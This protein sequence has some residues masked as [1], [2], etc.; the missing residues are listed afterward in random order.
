[1]WYCPY[2]YYEAVSATFLDP[3]VF[4]IIDSPPL[5]HHLDTYNNI[6]K[7]LPQCRWALRDWGKLP[8]ACT[9]PK[10]EK[11][12]AKGRPIVSFVGAMMRS[13]THGLA[14]IIYLML[15]QACP[16]ALG[17]GDAHHQ[18]FSLRQAFH[19]LST[20]PADEPFDVDVYNQDLSGFFTSIS[21]ERL[22]ASL[23]LMTQWYRGK[24]ATHATVFTATHQEPDPTIRVHR[25]RARFAKSR[26]HTIHLTR[27]PDICSAVLLLNYCLVGNTLLQQIRGAPMGSPASPALCDMVVA[28]S[29]QSWTHTYRNLTYNLKHTT[30]PMFTISGFFATRYVDNRLCL[31]PTCTR[32]NT[33]F[34][35][36]LSPQVYGHPIHLETE[37]GLDFL[38]FTIQPHNYS[39][40]YIPTRHL[41]DI[42]SPHSASPSTVLRSSLAARSILARRL[43]TPQQA[44]TQAMEQLSQVYERAGYEAQWIRRCLENIRNIIMCSHISEV[45]FPTQSAS[46]FPFPQPFTVFCD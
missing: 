41:T 27:L 1:M 34:Q 44:V 45:C 42:L 43:A 11:Q 32:H 40:Q 37:P 18:L 24:N 33:H 4:R 2:A 29:E 12:Y 9:L 26:R 5:T 46:Q 39:I 19:T 3:D 22:L 7:L 25:G 17:R 35:Q 38:G 16:Q 6:T 30:P 15:R 23:N 10:V 13:L 20:A 14:D 31:I 36:F 8:T 21:T 28:V